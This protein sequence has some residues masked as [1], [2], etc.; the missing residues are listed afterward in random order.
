[1]EERKDKKFEYSYRAPTEEERR[2]IECIRRF[3]GGQEEKFVRLKKLDARVRNVA[4]GCALS[5]GVFGCLVFGLGMSMILAWDL[6]AAGIAVATAGIVPMLSANPVYNAVLN[7][8]KKKYGD[9]ILR[10][11]EELKKSGKGE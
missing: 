2:E 8:N 3:Y 10:L 9:E 5:M 7:R 11:A 1:M 6:T 4:A